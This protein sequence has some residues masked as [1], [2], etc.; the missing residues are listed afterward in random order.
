[1]LYLVKSDNEALFFGDILSLKD[2]FNLP[3]DTPEND[4]VE[5]A[6]MS[7]SDKEWDE[8]YQGA[9]ISKGKIVLEPITTD[10]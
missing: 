4:I 10:A 8:K 9:H 1:M 5:K 7:F 2:Y 6:D 3:D